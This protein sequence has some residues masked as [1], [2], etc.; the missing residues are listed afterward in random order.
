V[1]PL[2]RVAGDAAWLCREA[3][4]DAE[5]RGL[6]EAYQIELAG[7]EG[8]GAG[9]A[10]GD[11]DG[12]GGGGGGAGGGGAGA[13]GAERR[14]GFQSVLM[15]T[16]RLCATLKKESGVVDGRK[17]YTGTRKAGAVAVANLIFRLMFRLQAP[18]L[19]G[20]VS[21]VLMQD[22]WLKEELAKSP[23]PAA[24]AAAAAAGARGAGTAG[25][26]SAAGAFPPAQV[27]T[28]R[29]YMGKL[30]LLEDAFAAAN[31]HLGAA[32]RWCPPGAAGAAHRRRVLELLVPVRLHLG[33]LPSPRLLAASGLEARYGGV[34]RGL[35]CGDLR[36]FREA[37]EAHLAAFI[38]AGVYLTL[39]KLQP[40]V[41]RALVRRCA[42][43]RGASHL[44]LPQLAGVLAGAAV[45]HASFPC[46]ADELEC[47]LAALIAAGRIKGYISH[48]P[49]FLVISKKDPFPK[50]R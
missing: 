10:G 40:L 11:D 2:L 6:Q 1:R 41:V 13:G 29:F 34:V 19:C 20:F 16:F 18:R 5:R 24:A 43:L 7:S 15:S 33:L 22:P 47:T 35:R 30:A 32:L 17:D 27:V 4:A 14:D 36:A 21:V 39:E 50:G 42:R 38:R 49:P 23:F 44:P 45:G 26:A 46:D 3:R 48:E 28:C 25:A 31:E 37:V 8:G 9:G 12:M